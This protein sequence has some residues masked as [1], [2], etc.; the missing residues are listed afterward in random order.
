ME[1]ILGMALTKYVPG[2]D[3]I[4]FY[5]A[6][7]SPSENWVETKYLRN[8]TI[9]RDNPNAAPEIFHVSL[10]SAETMNFSISIRN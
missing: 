3:R 4:L 9:F 7:S 10:F 5:H 8:Q 1:G 6:F 2:N